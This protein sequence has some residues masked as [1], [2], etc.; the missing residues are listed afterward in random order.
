[1]KAFYTNCEY[2]IVYCFLLETLLLRPDINIIDILAFFYNI[3]HRGSY[4][5]LCCYFHYH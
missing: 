5:F 3:L 1:M 2:I 4:E